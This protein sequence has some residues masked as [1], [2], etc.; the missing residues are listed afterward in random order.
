MVLLTKRS[1]NTISDLFGHHPNLYH[2]LINIL[3]FVSFTT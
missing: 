1:L 2:R 3:K